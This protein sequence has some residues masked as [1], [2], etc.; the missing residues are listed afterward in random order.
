MSLG[1]WAAADSAWAVSGEA[2]EALEA[3][4]VEQLRSQPQKA[5]EFNRAVLRDVFRFLA[6]DAGISFVSLPEVGQTE[7]KLVTF[8][9]RASPF[10][11]LEII[12]KANGVALFYEEGVW[13]LRPYNDK[14]LIARIYKLKYNTQEKVTSS[15]SAAASAPYATT[16]GPGGTAEGSVPD[17]GLSLQGVTDIFRT[18]PKQLVAD[19]RSLLG[20]PTSGF[21]AAN[22]G[23]V[24]VDASST[25]DIPQ[26][27]QPGSTEAPADN[28]AGKPG[29]P[30]VI[31]NSDSNTLYVVASR[32]QQQWVEGYLQSMDRP[33]P[34]IAIEVKFLETN[35]DPRKQL[36]VDWTGTLGDGFTLA[37]RQMVATPN[38]SINVSENGLEGKLAFQPARC[39]IRPV[40][41]VDRTR[42]S[43]RTF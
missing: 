15:D 24:T 1:L 28:V 16:S 37:A 4:I 13:Y 10:R 9:L 27:V 17:L 3:R 22:A 43:A 42:T 5:Y 39:G 25:L 34:L 11:A 32:Q 23:E 30:Q 35:K 41:A 7:E 21:E 8:A 19:I 38:G 6:D 31:W 18:D 2:N 20:I 40:S 14:E 36:G 12:A 29:G 33:Q 26:S